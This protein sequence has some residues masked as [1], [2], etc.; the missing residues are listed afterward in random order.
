MKFQI[1]PFLR[2]GKMKTSLSLRGLSRLKMLFLKLIDNKKAAS[3]AVQM[4]THHTEFERFVYF[5]QP[6]IV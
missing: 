4:F 6:N 1:L 5:K 2:V 3:R